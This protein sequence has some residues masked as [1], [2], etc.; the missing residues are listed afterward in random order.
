MSYESEIA[1]VLSK[2]TSTQSI[3]ILTESLALLL[4][5]YEF[6]FRS[7]GCVVGL[8]FKDKVYLGERQL[9]TEVPVASLITRTTLEH[10][11]SEEVWF[12]I[13]GSIRIP[14]VDVLLDFDL[15]RIPTCD[16]ERPACVVFMLGRELYTRV[17]GDDDESFDSF[18][19]STLLALSVR[20]GAHPLVDSFNC[21]IVGD[22]SD[23]ATFDAES[24]RGVVMNPSGAREAMAIARSGGLYPG[25]VFGVRTEIFPLSE[26]RQHYADVTET[27]NGFSIASDLVDFR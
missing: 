4:K 12:N 6:G 25:F 10:L 16:S 21:S 8:D 5:D 23:V 27:L 1:I 18:A 9:Q 19:A 22:L 17:Y 14:G 2:V 13:G 20:L 3:D 11:A 24:L 15:L 7:Y 26:I